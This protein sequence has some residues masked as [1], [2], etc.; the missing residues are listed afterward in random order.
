M[1]MPSRPWDMRVVWL[2]AKQRRWWNAWRESTATELHGF[3]DSR[4]SASRAMYRA[5]AEVGPPAWPQDE[6]REVDP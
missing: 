5:V 2:E 3:A 4:E 6:P 1:L